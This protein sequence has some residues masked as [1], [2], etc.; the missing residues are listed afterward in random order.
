M[1]SKP[2]VKI[3]YW[4]KEREREERERKKQRSRK[5]FDS[6]VKN[7]KIFASWVKSLLRKQINEGKSSFTQVMLTLSE[8]ERENCRKIV[9]GERVLWLRERGNFWREKE[10][11]SHLNLSESPE[12]FSLTRLGNISSSWN[13]FFL[14][15]IKKIWQIFRKLINK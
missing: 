4:T 10:N 2:R 5:F 7:H 15:K 13:V 6:D 12:E 8:N 9:F 1:F 11:F 14:N 3:S